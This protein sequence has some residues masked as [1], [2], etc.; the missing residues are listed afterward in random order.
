MADDTFIDTNTDVSDDKAILAAILETPK[1]STESK[2][3]EAKVTPP[4]AAK[5]D[6]TRQSPPEGDDSVETDEDKETP[7]ETPEY[8][9]PGPDDLDE[10]TVDVLVDG[11]KVEIPLKDLKKAYSAKTYSE[12]HIQKTA[13]ARKAAETEA[14]QLFTVNK[15][16]LDRLKVLDN[17]IA[18]SIPKIDWETLKRERPGEYLLK[19]EEFRENEEKQARV[20]AEIRRLDGENAHMS[21]VA[22]QKYIDDQA[23]IL[24]TKIPA[25]GDKTKANDVMN[26]LTEGAGKYYNYSKEEV[27]GIVDHR[28]LLILNDAI[29]WR[30]H[31]EKLA[32][33]AKEETK[34]VPK[35][36][37]LRPGS[38]SKDAPSTSQKKLDAA[39]LA[40]AQRSGKPDDVA[41][42]LI[43]RKKA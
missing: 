37:M 3:E 5:P 24:I 40:R 32:A 38:G 1:S 18:A 11:K 30:K 42:L 14:Q 41:S 33:A 7:E 36:I 12:Q 39:N 28:P 25:L 19:R 16:T 17:V 9:E 15:E 34:T 20:Q 31:Q 35:K 21:K 43:V 29:S 2:K 22:Q 4:V 13:E 8:D 27:D 26:N 10:Y 23:S 6:P